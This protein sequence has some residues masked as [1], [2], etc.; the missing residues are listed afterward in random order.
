MRGLP[1]LGP[2]GE[3]GEDRD[4]IARHMTEVEQ[5]PADDGTRPYAVAAAGRDEPHQYF[6]HSGRVTRMSASR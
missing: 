6:L 3:G 2:A 5:P 1:G 4:D